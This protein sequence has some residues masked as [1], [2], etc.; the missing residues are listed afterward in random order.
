MTLTEFMSSRGL[1]AGEKKCYCPFHQ[2]RSPSAMC[3]PNHIHCFVCRREYSFVD[4]G[5]LFHVRLEY[6][7]QSSVLDSLHGK[8]PESD[9][10]FTYPWFKEE[11]T[12]G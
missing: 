6:E 7:P 5:K 8:L 11:T 1:M 4:V 12:N 3:N 9:I 10:L 2:D